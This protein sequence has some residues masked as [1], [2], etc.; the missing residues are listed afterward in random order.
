MMNRE[1]IHCHWKRFSW[2]AVI[3]G[4]LVGLG[5]IFLLCLFSTVIGL[6]AF[7][8]NAEGMVTI[9]VAVLLGSLLAYWYVC[10][11]LGSG[12][13]RSPYCRTEFRRLVRLCRLVF[14]I[15]IH[16]RPCRS[17]GRYVSAI[18]ILFPPNAMA[19]ELRAGGCGNGTR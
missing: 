3:V 11:R 6:S 14:G 4:G 8:M 18:P 10:G 7:S 2:T 9:A 13:F 1:P 15:I 19:F 17:L 16:G 12:V 5:L